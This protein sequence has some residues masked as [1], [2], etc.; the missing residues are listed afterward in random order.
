MPCY[1]KFRRKWIARV[2]ISGQSAGTKAFDTKREA[3][4][5]EAERRKQKDLPPTGQTDTTFL[6][7]YSEYLDFASGRYTQEHIHRKGCPR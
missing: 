4:A 2:R 1:N 6:D 3:L 7:A 5:W